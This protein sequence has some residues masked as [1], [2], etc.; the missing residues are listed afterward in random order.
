VREPAD[1]SRIPRP[2]FLPAHGRIK[3][4]LEIPGLDRAERVALERRLGSY[5]GSC[6]C[7]TG[8]VGVGVGICLYL[9]YALAGLGPE[10]SPG[11]DLLAKA[12]LAAIAGGALGK[13]LGVIGAILA[14]G[15]ACR[16]VLGSSW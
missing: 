14:L 12:L 16:Q 1:L 8:A 5:A 7:R 6:G 4:R 3:V 2:G 11:T 13:V 15:R 9:P 10:S